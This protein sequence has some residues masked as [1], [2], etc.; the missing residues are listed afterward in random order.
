MI[1]ILR[2]IR[3]GDIMKLEDFNIAYP[4]IFLYK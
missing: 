2:S 4:F 3:V 1:L